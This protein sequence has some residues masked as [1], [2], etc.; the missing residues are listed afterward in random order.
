MTTVVHVPFPLQVMGGQQAFGSLAQLLPL[1]MHMLDSG[2]GMVT[3]C[4]VHWG[5]W[6]C[7]VM[8]WKGR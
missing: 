3:T 5:V 6:L 1:P 4:C 7:F 8:S 2:T